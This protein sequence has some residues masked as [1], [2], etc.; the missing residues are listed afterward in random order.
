MIHIIHISSLVTAA[1]ALYLASAEDLE[2]VACFLDFQEIIES[3]RKIK[4][5]LTDLL[6]SRHD[7]QS[8]STKAFR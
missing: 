7:L 2:T 4:K 1:E 8:A 3:P 6:V 5:P